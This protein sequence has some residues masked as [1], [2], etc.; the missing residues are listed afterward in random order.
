MINPTAVLTKLAEVVQ[1]R[2][3]GCVRLRHK[4]ARCQECIDH[5][6]TGAI[7]VGAAGE[8]ITIEWNKCVGCG[9]CCTVCRTGVYTPKD[10]SDRAFLEKCRQAV[11]SGKEIEIHCK[12]AG[13]GAHSS[14]I[15][16]PCLGILD[17]AHLIGMV[18]YG[19]SS[20]YLRHAECSGCSARHG[21]RCA[22]K[23]AAATESLLRI[24]AP[25]KKVVI[26]AGT[27][28]A[29]FTRGEKDA[30]REGP[31]PGKMVSRRELFRYFRLNA[32]FAAAETADILL[33]EPHRP[34]G[35]R[36]RHTGFL[37]ERRELLIAFLK[38][39][40]N[41]PER[42]Q[43]SAGC[44]LM[45]EL[46]IDGSEC[47]RCG[48]CYHFCPTHALKEYN[49]SDDTSGAAGGWG[50]RFKSSDCVKC[51]LCLVVCYRKAI[52]YTDYIDIGRFLEEREWLLQAEKK[53]ESP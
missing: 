11:M 37:P 34:E 19:A 28:P 15:E 20:L 3:N 32:L 24:F 49:A 5:C 8:E 38:R 16:V 45:A 7:Q 52:R 23:S 18:V 4:D 27:D 33:E 30:K 36:I 53:P 2:K 35:E 51:D 43:D 1:I 48:M 46:E 44:S 21:D 13:G 42:I 40:G 47:D 39:L 14:G 41:P 10:F 9:I 12:Q 25:A 22:S 17:P 31:E 26:T 29:P 50:I 6:P